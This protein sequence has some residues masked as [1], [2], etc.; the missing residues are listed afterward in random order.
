[1]RGVRDNR[2]IIGDEQ[3]GTT[4]E[5]I[6]SCGRVNRPDTRVTRRWKAAG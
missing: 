3:I 5:C 4:I 1:M 2:R 6:S